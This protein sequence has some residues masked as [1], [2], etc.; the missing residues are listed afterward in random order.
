MLSFTTLCIAG[1]AGLAACAPSPPHPFTWNPSS[2]SLKTCDA[3]TFNPTADLTPSNWRDCASLS[4]TWA[5][6]NGSFTINPPAADVLLPIVKYET[7]TL[8]VNARDTTSLT[9]GDVD[10]GAILTGTLLGFSQG[11]VLSAQGDVLCEAGGEE[12][13]G[14]HWQIYDSGN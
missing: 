11:S 8:A 9:V 5:T 1:L 4:S 7:C 2:T 3:S 13:K 10:I 14:L 6:V 12:K